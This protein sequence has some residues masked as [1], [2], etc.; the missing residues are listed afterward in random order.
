MILFAFILMAVGGL[1]FAEMFRISQRGLH[2]LEIKSVIIY[3]FRGVLQLL[4][5]CINIAAVVILFMEKWWLGIVGIAVALVGTLLHIFIF[6]RMDPEIKQIL[7]G[8]SDSETIN[9]ID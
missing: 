2:G 8:N 3:N 4:S 1:L 5:V 9:R 6:S 7:F